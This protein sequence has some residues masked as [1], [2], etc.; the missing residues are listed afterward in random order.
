MYS[1]TRG[2]TAGFIAQKVYGDPDRRPELK[3]LNGIT[4]DKSLPGRAMPEGL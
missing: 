2:Q 1:A 3:K 4:N